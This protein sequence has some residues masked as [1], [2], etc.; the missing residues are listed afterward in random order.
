MPARAPLGVLVASAIV[1]LAAAPA[2]AQTHAPDLPPDLWDP[3]APDR[4]AAASSSGGLP[5]AFALAAIV[6][7]AV[8]GFVVGDRLPGL[9]R[10][11]RASARFDTCWI[12]IWRSGTS[13]EFRAVVGSGAGRWVVGRSP[14]FT[15]PAS[16]PIPE[17]G[18]ARA[19][20]DELVERLRSLGW[21]L[22]GS[23]TGDWYQLRFEQRPAEALA[24][25]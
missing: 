13:A 14:A 16:G 1:A 19:A 20:H 12:A 11:A 7:V 6:L 4:A 3:L 5:I 24:L 21:E 23:E 25:T 9:T 18:P 10:G 22:T 2:A 17:D 8:A 15:A